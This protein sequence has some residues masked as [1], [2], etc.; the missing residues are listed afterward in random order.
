MSDV[1]GFYRLLTQEIILQVHLPDPPIDSDVL[2]NDF[3]KK[4][5]IKA[6]PYFPGLKQLAPSSQSVLP[7]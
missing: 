7:C 2:D 5:K 1:K 4:K 3:E 6:A